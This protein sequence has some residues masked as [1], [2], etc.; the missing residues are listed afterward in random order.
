MIK[1]SLQFVIQRGLLDG[2]NKP[3]VVV[4]ILIYPA[5]EVFESVRKKVVLRVVT[6]TLPLSPS[7]RYSSEEGTLGGAS[8]STSV[9]CAVH[10][11]PTYPGG[12]LA[13]W[14]PQQMYRPLYTEVS[15][16]GGSVDCIP[17]YCGFFRTKNQFGALLGQIRKCY[18]LKGAK[19]HS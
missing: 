14:P 5:S 19:I 7:I 3:M 9:K 15:S 10:S 16:A 12:R 11:A 4:S 17:E 13:T 1:K 2:S 8:H 18:D 6:D